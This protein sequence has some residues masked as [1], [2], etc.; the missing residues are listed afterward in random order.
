MS[1]NHSKDYQHLILELIHTL[2]LIIYT[3]AWEEDVFKHV[4]QQTNFLKDING[5]KSSPKAA[6]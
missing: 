6:L 2:F 1:Q 5:R 4:T 3:G